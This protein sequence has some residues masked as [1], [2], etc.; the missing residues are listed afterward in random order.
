[1]KIEFTHGFNHQLRSS[2]VV[3]HDDSRIVL[4]DVYPTAFKEGEMPKTFDEI[5]AHW[6]RRSAKDQAELFALYQVAINGIKSYADIRNVE[7][8]ERLIMRSVKP[9]LTRILK[10]HNPVAMRR[11][12]DNVY[13][14]NIPAD[15]LDIAPE[16]LTQKELYY[17]RD[18]Y[19]ALQTLVF[20]LRSIAP[21]LLT[22]QQTFK[23]Y[24]YGNETS[25]FHQKMFTLLFDGSLRGLYSQPLIKLEN[26]ITAYVGSISMS[27]NNAQVADILP[28]L[29][30]NRFLACNVS[31]PRSNLVCSAYVYIS[32]SAHCDGFR[33]APVSV[34]VSSHDGKTYKTDY[35]IRSGSL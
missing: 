20:S 16:N 29:V 5:N 9:F 10:M 28:K 23:F 7:N 4:H 12:L 31:S 33:T 14:D 34:T 11:F 3:S 26:Y 18:D 25:D 8:A 22:L 24:S 27:K 15:I 1:M 6:A 32:Q 19:C 21:L 13:E 2:I 30:L 17:T 35:K